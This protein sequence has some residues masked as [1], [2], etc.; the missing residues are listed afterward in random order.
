MGKLHLTNVSI[1][2][3]MNRPLKFGSKDKVCGGG[4]GGGAEQ[5]VSKVILV[6]SLSLS[7]AEQKKTIANVVQLP[8]EE[9]QETQEGGKKDGCQQQERQEIGVQV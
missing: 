1:L 6:I 7:Q 3:E 5:H 4:D 9:E 2:H 8:R